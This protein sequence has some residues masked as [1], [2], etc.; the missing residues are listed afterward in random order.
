MA[1][2]LVPILIMLTNLATYPMRP[3]AIEL[4]FG[5]SSSSIVALV[6][7]HGN[8]KLQMPVTGVLT[9]AD[10]VMIGCYVAI[11]AAFGTSL[12]ILA[13]KLE[14]NEAR[15]ESSQIVQ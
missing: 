11:L 12:I 2:L 3:S 8:L 9:L 15:A 5:V 1:V 13:A 6:L 4:R 7:Y 10:R 14:N